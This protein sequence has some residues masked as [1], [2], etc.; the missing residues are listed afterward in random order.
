LKFNNDLLQ[1]E[2]HITF[3]GIEID[4]S[5]NW[6]TQV[7][8]IV[9]E[10][11]KACFVIRK[12]KLYSNIETLKMIYYAHFHLLKGYRIVFWGNL[13]EAKKIFLLQKKAIRIIMEMKHR[14]SCR[15]AFKKLNILTLTSQYILS[16]MTI[17][18]NNLEYFTFNYTIHNKL[19]RHGR[20]LH[21]LQSH[22]AMRQ[23]GVWESPTTVTGHTC[24]QTTVCGLHNST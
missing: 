11:G 8:S 12:M 22:L 16:L 2:T 10:L 6:K 21:V 23:K 15:P 9:P 13:S 7:K 19:T 4:K 24:Y 5:L 14:E 3:L 18:A 1:E 17:M 20:N